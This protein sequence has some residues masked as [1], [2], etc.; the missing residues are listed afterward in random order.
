[1]M[2]SKNHL[3][4]ARLRESGASERALEVYTQARAEYEQA[5]E[6]KGLARVLLEEAIVFLHQF[7]EEERS[8]VLRVSYMPR[9]C[10]LTLSYSGMSEQA[11]P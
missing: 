4:G 5:E 1:M 7:E 9:S 10:P 2:P 11:M 3:E 8:E 6:W